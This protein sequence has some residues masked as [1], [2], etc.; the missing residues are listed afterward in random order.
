M[1]K[2]NCTNG[3]QYG[4]WQ[5]ENEKEVSRICLTCNYKQIYPKT[6][7]VLKEYKQ[8]IIAIKYL[9][10]FLK[11]SG[12]DDNLISFINLIFDDVLGFIG[13]EHTSILLVKLNEFREKSTLSE[14]NKTS[15]EQ[16]ISH[17]KNN[18]LEELYKEIDK[19]KSNNYFTLN[20]P[21]IQEQ[22]N[23]SR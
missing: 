11:V 22:T 5:I 6:S 17:K 9:N 8:Q 1:E 10:H 15:L 13:P 2:N 19:F 23:L 7:E 4:L 12:D 20:T 3:H 14:E 18:N 16:I 21:P